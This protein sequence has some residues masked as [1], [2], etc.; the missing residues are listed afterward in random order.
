MPEK[1]YIRAKHVPGYKTL[2]MFISTTSIYFVFKRQT[3]LYTEK[4]L[5]R[6]I[7]LLGFTAISEF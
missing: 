3:E 2:T 5:K 7:N 6:K 4:N 1:I